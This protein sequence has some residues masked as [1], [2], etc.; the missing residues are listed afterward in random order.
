MINREH[1]DCVVIGGGF[2]GLYIAEFMSHR[3]PNVL[4]CE[5][6]KD[7]MQR[8]SL[9]N[10]AR[11]HSGYHYP[12]S[13]LTA[14][15][16][17]VSFPKF[18]EE[19]KDCIDDN[20]DKYYAVGRILSKVTAKQFSL[21]CN[22]IGAFCEPAPYSIVKL[23]EPQFIEA[24]FSVREYAFDAARMKLHMVNRLRDSGVEIQVKSLVT[25]VCQRDQGGMTLQ[26]ST[27]DGAVSIV[28]NRVINCLSLIHI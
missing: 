24:V 3:L 12:R 25:R 21:F 23:F 14:L 10:Q 8:A 15:R 1:Y 7:V 2:F 26:V 13:I 6:E 11:V 20:F 18:V 17:R 27:K 22:R 16:A 4:V 19:F 9:A 28:A 5:K